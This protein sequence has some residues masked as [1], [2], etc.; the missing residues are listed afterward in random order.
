MNVWLPQILPPLASHPVAVSLDTRTTR[1][2]PRLNYT[3]TCSDFD[4]RH[5]VQS[6]KHPEALSILRRA[7]GPCRRRC[8]RRRRQVLTYVMSG[9]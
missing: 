8:R 5:V 6:Q 1:D 3:S 4:T 2:E 7:S 9:V